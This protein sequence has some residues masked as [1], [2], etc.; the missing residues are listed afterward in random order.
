MRVSGAITTRCLSEYGPIAAAEK[1]EF[2]T[3]FLICADE[4][5]F[6]E[7]TMGVKSFER[8]TGS[9]DIINSRRE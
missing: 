1:S 8:Q 3:G 2:M 6:G 4:L 5:C 9:G 7:Q